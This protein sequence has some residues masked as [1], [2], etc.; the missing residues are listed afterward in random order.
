MCNNML[1]TW[2]SRGDEYSSGHAM[3]KSVD[4]VVD[5]VCAVH[6]NTCNRV[7]QGKQLRDVTF[8]KLPKNLSKKGTFTKDLIANYGGN[9]QK[10]CHIGQGHFRLD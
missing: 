9:K 8:Q 3:S 6:I 5:D 10:D 2:T 1:G 7:A 4:K